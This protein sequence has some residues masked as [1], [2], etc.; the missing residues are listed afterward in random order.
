MKILKKRINI[1]TSKPSVKTLF[2]ENET[3]YAHYNASEI[4]FE[5]NKNHQIKIYAYIN[6]T[7]CKLITIEG[8]N[9]FD[10]FVNNGLKSIVDYVVKI[11]KLR[12]GSFFVHL[13]R[14]EAVDFF[15]KHF[16]EVYVTE[17]YIRGNSQPQYHCCFMSK[18][19]MYVNALKK[20]QPVNK[21]KTIV[22]KS[23]LLKLASYKQ[24]KRKKQFLEKLI[25]RYE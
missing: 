5:N 8:V 23:D 1:E 10:H 21:K 13:T 19:S 25:E 2:Y 14:K 9:F 22:N 3:S 7:N 24:E 4:I 17:T 16:K 6:P 12:N 15:K 11:L 18:T 20:Y